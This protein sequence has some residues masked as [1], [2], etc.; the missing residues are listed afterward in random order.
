MGRTVK[1][2]NRR[3]KMRADQRRAKVAKLYL[4]GRLL[5]EIAATVECTVRTV[6][7]DLNALQA[8]WLEEGKAFYTQRQIRELQRLDVLECE[9]AE[10]WAKSKEIGL[11]EMNE[12]SLG[13]KDGDK[14]VNRTTRRHQV[15]DPRFLAEM[16]SC[17]EQRCK[18]LG[19]YPKEQKGQNGEA[20]DSQ[21]GP[22]E[23]R[24]IL[25][26]MSNAELEAISAPYR[27]YREQLTRRF[28]CLN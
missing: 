25:A 14:V 4:V 20:G 23:L 19:L 3:Q 26:E 21:Q 5:T 27:K 18:I 9:A 13:G 7:D 15:G 28:S 17:I 2:H 11:T 22:A 12:Q 24:K 10:A 16:R 6:T 8:Q 1:S